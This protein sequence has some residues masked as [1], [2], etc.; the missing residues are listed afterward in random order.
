M[1]ILLAV[2]AGK[3]GRTHPKTQFIKKRPSKKDFL[4][5]VCSSSHLLYFKFPVLAEGWISNWSKS[6]FIFHWQQ[7]YQYC[8]WDY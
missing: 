8:T 7:K 3:A 1:T 2:F 6:H 4:L 5:S